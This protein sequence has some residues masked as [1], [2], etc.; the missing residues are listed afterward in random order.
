MNTAYLEEITTLLDNQNLNYEL[1]DSLNI[2]DFNNF[3]CHYILIENCILYAITI[4]QVN[5][6]KSQFFFKNLQEAAQLNQEQKLTFIMDTSHLE[7]IPASAREEIHFFDLSFR[8]YWSKFLFIYDGIGKV[9]IDLYEIHKPEHLIGVEKVSKPKLAIDYAINSK[10]PDPSSDD[11]LN[12]LSR[13]ELIK[14][15][16]ELKAKVNVQNEDVKKDENQLIDILNNLSWKGKDT[17]LI[18][19]ENVG[20]LIPVHGLLNT[21]ITDFKALNQELDDLRDEFYDKLQFQVGEVLHQE[22]TLRAI[23]DNLESIVWMVDAEYNILAFNNKFHQHV[24]SHY[25]ISPEVGMNLLEQSELASQ[26]D[27]TIKRIDLALNGKEERYRDFYRENGIVIKVVDSKIFP[28]LVNK[29]INGIVCI[30]DDITQNFEAK[31]RIKNNERIIASVNKNISEAIYRS[32]HDKGL[33]FVNEAFVKMFGFES[34]DELYHHA[35]LN[36]LYANPDDR[37]RLGNLLIKKKEVTNVEVQFRKKNGE[38]FTGLISSMVSEEEEGAATYFDGAIR[39][40]T[41]IKSAQEKLK[42]QNRELKKLNTELDS[43]V[44]SAS[45]DLKAPLSSIKGLINLAKN[46][47]DKEQLANY[48]DLVDQSIN[49]LDDFIKDIVDLSRNSRQDVKSEP[50]DFQQIVKDTLENYQYLQNYDKIEKQIEIDSDVDFYSDKRRLKVIF[51]NLISNSIR[52]FNP[53]IDNPYVKISIKTDKE[54]S[55]IKILDNGLGIENQYLEKIFDMFFRAS[56]N[57]KGTG[58]GLYIVKETIQKVNG[59]IKVES[60]IEKGTT[61]TVTIPNLNA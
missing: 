43:F 33:I 9:I 55:V 49:K 28:V 45:H 42:K 27:N 24:K 30:T 40:V 47:N 48:L 13:Q 36:S 26:Y 44:Y 46:E 3:N 58:I 51:N 59:E 25:G 29:Y 52:Y 2:V 18:K 39:D 31:E 11:Y 20:N 53:Y 60:E 41:A 17:N 19:E 34:K 14:E 54:K 38:T 37:E 56:N 6:K 35:K 1:L 7:S 5:G 12:S 57:S 50:I 15:I 21:I 8:K 32:T 4:G 61:F 22:A 23:F 16:K 10:K